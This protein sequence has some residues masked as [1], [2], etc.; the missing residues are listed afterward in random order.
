VPAFA[1]A[2]AIRSAAG[3]GEAALAFIGELATATRDRDPSKR[4]HELPVA[5]RVAV[6]FGAADLARGMT[7]DGEPNY[8]RSRLC[9]AASRAMLAE[10][11]GALEEAS[12]LHAEAAE[13]LAAY[14][15]PWE[16]AQAQV[17][18]ARC[19]LATGRPE[20]AGPRLTRAREI[21]VALGARPLLDE[22]ARLEA[23]LAA[24][25]I[26]PAEASA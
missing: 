18:A 14:G 11:D 15:W 20:E 24:P 23:G 13:A 10:S 1:T 6:K 7:P 12:R 5:T 9:I 16:E 2:A 22:I 19:L 25:A 3:D 4:A 26:E 21:A 8:L 17:G